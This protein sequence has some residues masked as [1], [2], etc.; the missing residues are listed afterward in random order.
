MIVEDLNR[1]QQFLLRR[2]GESAHAK[3][4]CALDRLR[5]CLV[6]A[7]AQWDDMTEEQKYWC[8]A[9]RIVDEFEAGVA[10]RRG[11]MGFLLSALRKVNPR[12]LFPTAWKVLGAWQAAVPMQQAPA[13]PPEVLVAMMTLAVALPPCSSPHSAQ[14]CSAVMHVCFGCGRL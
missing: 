8:L 5:Q 1:V 9:E 12:A 7:G 13:A 4:R 14:R 3:Y 6:A 11:E 10:G 2:L